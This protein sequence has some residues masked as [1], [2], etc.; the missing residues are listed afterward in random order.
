MTPQTQL[1]YAYTES[2]LLKQGTSSTF[3]IGSFAPS[4]TANVRMN[5]RKIIDFDSLDNKENKLS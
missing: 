2:P 1:L 4:A 3:K 5:S